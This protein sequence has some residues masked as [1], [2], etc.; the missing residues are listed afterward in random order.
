[1]VEDILHLNQVQV[2]EVL[3]VQVEVVVQINNPLQVVD[4]VFNLLNLVNLALMDLEVMVVQEVK[5]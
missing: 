3:V 5:I 4:L 1:M 2:L